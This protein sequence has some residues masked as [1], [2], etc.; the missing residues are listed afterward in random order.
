MCTLLRCIAF[1]CVVLIATNTCAVLCSSF[2]PLTVHEGTETEWKYTSALSVT[3]SLDG[4]VDHRQPSAALPSGNT[5]CPVYGR[6]GPP[7]PSG[8][9][10]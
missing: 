8:W 6:V 2:R 4:V 3:S 9:V 5:L 10:R 7:G 1:I